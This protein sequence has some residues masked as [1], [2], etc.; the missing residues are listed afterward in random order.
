MLVAA[1]AGHGLIA[2]LSVVVYTFP[3][4]NLGVQGT[5]LLD[6]SRFSRLPRL[7]SGHTWVS[8]VPIVV[9]TWVS[10]IAGHATVP[11]PFADSQS[12]PNH[13]SGQGSHDIFD[14]SGVVCPGHAVLAQVPIVVKMWFSAIAG[15]AVMAHPSVDDHVFPR[16]GVGHATHALFAA[17]G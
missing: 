17:F 8:Q 16:D 5:Q 12:C 1:I 9:Q 10:G 7:S 11:H 6:S 2:Q 14:A 15:Q 13:R 4:R 3:F